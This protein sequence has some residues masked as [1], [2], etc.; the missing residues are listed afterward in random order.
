MKYY[1]LWNPW[2]MKSEG[3]S[4]TRTR[5]PYL[6][7]H[8]LVLPTK[9]EV[10]RDAVACEGVCR[11]R[12]QTPE[13]QGKEEAVPASVIDPS[14]SFCVFFCA[15]LLRSGHF[16]QHTHAHVSHLFK[17]SEHTHKHT[18]VIHLLEVLITQIQF[19]GFSCCPR[20][21]APLPRH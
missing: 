9:E 1:Q 17:D 18:H 4:Q 15:A 8:Q 3:M 2:P 7:I 10:V 16:L 14:S 12:G 11:G 20:S 19:K 21:A 5:W 13:G 6:L